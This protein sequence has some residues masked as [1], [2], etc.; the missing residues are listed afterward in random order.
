MDNGKQ[1]ESIGDSEIILPYS[2]KSKYKIGDSIQLYNTVERLDN[3]N[4]ISKDYQ[5]VG[6]T[7]ENG[8]YV[9]LCPSLESAGFQS[10]TM[11]II[12]FPNIEDTIDTNTPE[13]Q[14]YP[15]PYTLDSFYFLDNSS[16]QYEIAGYFCT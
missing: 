7:A 1:L 5:V 4:Y 11:P 2:M 3:G 13:G 12:S 10:I 6:F 15:F 9:S 16:L 14:W 8:Q